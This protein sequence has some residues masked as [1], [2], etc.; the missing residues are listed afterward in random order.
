[1]SLHVTTD[2]G[3]PLYQ[4]TFMEYSWRLR[5]GGFFKILETFAFLCSSL[6]Q[7]I[8]QIKQFTYLVRGGTR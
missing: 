8:S 6:T 7:G 1:M 2:L 3:G 5:F 4:N